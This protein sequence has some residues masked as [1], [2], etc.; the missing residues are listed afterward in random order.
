M[1]RSTA[2]AATPARSWRSSC[3]ASATAPRSWRRWMPRQFADALA[4]G[5]GLCAR[6]AQRAA[7]GHDPHGA[8]PISRPRPQRPARGGAPDFRA[9]FR[10]A[11]AAARTSLDATPIEARDAAPR[12]RRRRRRARLRRARGGHGG[13]LRDRHRAGR[14]RGD[15]AAARRRDHR[16]LADGP[17]APLL[18]RVHDHRRG[19]RPAQAARGGLDARRR[20]S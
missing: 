5:V 3:W 15:P 9:L 6:V 8:S 1:P 11:L 20:A 19:D 13:L 16:G 7:R 17:R 10:Q 18:H 14:R 4:A 12:E 2:R